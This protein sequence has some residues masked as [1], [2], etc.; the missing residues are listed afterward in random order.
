MKKAALYVRKSTTDKQKNSFQVQLSN[1]RQ[2]CEGHF[3]IV[4]TFE[5]QMTGRTLDREGLNSAI[6]WLNG[7]SDRVLIVYKVDRLGR[8]LD[9]FQKIRWFIEG[10]RI[11]FMDMHSPDSKADLLTIQIKLSS[12]KMNPE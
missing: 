4:E 3:E 7:S 5:D 12:R 6:E 11:L 9:D 1:M 2:Y 8:T 10:G